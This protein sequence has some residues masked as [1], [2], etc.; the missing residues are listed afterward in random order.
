MGLRFSFYSRLETQLIGGISLRATG[1]L[2]ESR[3]VTGEKKR[4]PEQEEE[5]RCQ[6]KHGRKISRQRGRG[7]PNGGQG[8]ERKIY[9]NEWFVIPQVC[10]TACLT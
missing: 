7:E 1:I 8:E 10:Q 2:K 9:R 3:R 6:W 5:G 4:G